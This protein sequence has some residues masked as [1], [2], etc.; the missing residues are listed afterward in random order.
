MASD[1]APRGR[2]GLRT[3]LTAALT[4][5]RVLLAVAA[6][7]VV[8]ELSAAAGN[9]SAVVRAG[10]EGFDARSA[11]LRDADLDPLASFASTGAL[12]LAREAI[13]DDATYTVAVG[14]NTPVRDPG[15]V[16]LVFRLWLQP[17]RYTPRLSEAQWIV[18][19]HQSSEGLKVPFT[20]EIGLG[21]D[22]NLLEVAR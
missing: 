7:A 17:R 16:R 5:R 10:R 18:T 2:R 22:A 15:A 9:V 13:P 3:A 21:P 14:E 11:I 12:A 19:Y 20:R 8:V 4:D 6:V 1:E